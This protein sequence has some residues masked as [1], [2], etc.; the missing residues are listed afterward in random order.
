MLQV[1][2]RR[3]VAAEPVLLRPAASTYSLNSPVLPTGVCSMRGSAQSMASVAKTTLAYYAA[4]TLSS[5][6]LGMML[7]S[8]LRPGRG[9][10]L[11][12]AAGS[13]GA[14]ATEVSCGAG[15]RLHLCAWRQC[16]CAPGGQL[17]GQ[18]R[19]MGHGR[20]L[21]ILHGPAWYLCCC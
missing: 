9:S 19:C 5:V 15:Q 2:I 21:H 18:Q 1:K 17:L 4:N 7:V 20:C 10:P 6:L 8:L 11:S 3:S 13:C 16:C 14:S 12:S